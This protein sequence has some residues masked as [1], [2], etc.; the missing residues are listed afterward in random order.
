MIYTFLSSTPINALGLAPAD[1]LFKVNRSSNTS[2]ES[3]L[4]GMRVN[5]IME[6]AGK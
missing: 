5:T 1:D 4:R 6:C 3:P 2:A